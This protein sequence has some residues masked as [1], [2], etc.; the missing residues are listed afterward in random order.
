MLFDHLVEAK[1]TFAEP[2]S[3]IA[4]HRALLVD[5][6]TGPFAQSTARWQKSRSQRGFKQRIGGRG[7]DLMPHQGSEE[8][9][10]RRLDE[11][12]G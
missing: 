2:G 12:I 7:S 10:L 1:S 4:S 9:R 6:R 3:L 11:Y 8:V 5:G